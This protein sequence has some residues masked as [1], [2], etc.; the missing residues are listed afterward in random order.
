MFTKVS[1]PLWLLH[2]FPTRHQ[3]MM[4]QCAMPINMEQCVIEFLVLITVR[5]LFNGRPLI[6]LYIDRHR[7]TLH[8]DPSCPELCAT[9]DVC[10]LIWSPDNMGRMAADLMSISDIRHT[11]RWNLPLS[12]LRRRSILE[13]SYWWQLYTFIYLRMCCSFY[14]YL[15]IIK[16]S[17][18]GYPGATTGRKSKLT[19][20][21]AP[22]FLYNPI[23]TATHSLGRCTIFI[24]DFFP[25]WLSLRNEGIRAI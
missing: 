20:K 2:S 12:F 23:K 10:H 17:P 5:E 4:D 1:I 22:F 7:S 13:K 24:N 19:H 9:H 21:S 11:G 6:W 16:S 18:T 3:Y 15:P 14:C 8:I 25:H